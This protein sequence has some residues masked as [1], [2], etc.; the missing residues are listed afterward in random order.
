M[1]FPSTSTSWKTIVHI[2]TRIMT[3]IASI[4]HIQSS[5]TCILFMY[6]SVQFYCMCTIVYSPPVKIQNSAFT[7]GSLPWSFHNHIHPL[8][9]PLTQPLTLGNDY[10]ALYFYH[11][12]MLYKWN[13][14]VSKLLGLP[15]FTQ[16]NSLQNHPSCCTCQQLI[17]FIAK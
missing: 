7:T 5:F 15:F 6:S 1:Q 8:P 16:P 12:T 10:S 2:T 3:W 17:S 11:S 9:S 13:H 14:A 4:H